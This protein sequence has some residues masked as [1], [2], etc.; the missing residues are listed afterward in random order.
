M[1]K[2]EARAR[3]DGRGDLF[4]NAYIWPGGC[5]ILI[6]GLLMLRCTFE[7]WGLLQRADDVFGVSVRAVLLLAAGLHLL[8]TVWLVASRDLFPRGILVFSIGLSHLVY[9]AGL[10]WL[11][12]AMP[13]TILRVLGMETGIR[14]QK[15]DVCWKWFIAWLVG[16]GLV[17]LALE[18]RNFRVRQSEAFLASWRM[19][20]A[21][22]QIDSPKQDNESTRAF[23]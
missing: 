22:G 14:A 15:L 6:A 8:A 7:N 21:A 5:L 4:A 2:K 17:F 16:G 10:S 11:K 23:H 20:R 12:A 18:W 1:Q 13:L 19:A 9:R 3:A